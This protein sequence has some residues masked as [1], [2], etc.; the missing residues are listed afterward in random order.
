MRAKANAI[1]EKMMIA[2]R[3]KLSSPKSIDHTP[4]RHEYSGNIQ[5]TNLEGMAAGFAENNNNFG[6]LFVAFVVVVAA[7]AAFL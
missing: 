5:S 4:G 6:N 3:H 1:D 2:T 7:S